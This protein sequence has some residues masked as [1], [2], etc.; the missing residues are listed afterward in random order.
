[1]RLPF[2]LLFLLTAVAHAQWDLEVPPTTADLRGV[3][4]TGGGAVWASGTNGTVVRSE[5][6]GYLWQACSIP[7]GAEKLDFRGIQALDENVAIV[8]SSGPGDLSRLYKTVD[9]C[10]SWKLV[11][12]NPDKRGFWD[13]LRRAT[14]KQLYLLGDPVGGK[15]AMF[16]SADNGESWS[17]AANPGLDAE[18][19]AGAFAASNSS[20]IAE[21]PLLLFGGGGTASP[22]LYYSYAKCDPSQ[23]DV[24]CPMAWA[25][26]EVPIAGG[27]P[28]AG[29]FSLTARTTTN[30]AGTNSLTVVAVGGVYDKPAAANGT[31]ATSKDGGRTWLAATTPPHGYRS[32]VSYDS[33]GKTLIAV[34]PNGTDISTDDGRNWRALKALKGEAPDTDQHWNALSLPFAV[35]PKGRIG[36]LNSNA[37]PE[38]AK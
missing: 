30:V 16:S 4:N 32:A 7:P 27:A 9:G 5:D 10:R 8:M 21:G 19:D 29:I 24:S 35:G 2:V 3:S 31:A 36:K 37:L 20:L 18:S 17:V 28:A 23:T 1:M 34:G 26:T 25:K 12:T 22:H 6:G 15:F 38:T 11:F 33:T 14:S 13:S